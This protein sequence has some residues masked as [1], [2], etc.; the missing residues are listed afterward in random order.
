MAVY[1]VQGFFIFVKQL[2]SLLVQ[3]TIIIGFVWR[4]FNR[5]K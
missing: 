5:D 4:T 2:I 1:T 3:P